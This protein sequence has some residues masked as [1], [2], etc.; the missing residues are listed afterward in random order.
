MAYKAFPVIDL[1][2]TGDNIRRLRLER[3]LT[4]KDLQGYFGFEEPRAIYKWQKG[5]TLPTVDNL[6]ALGV[7]FEVP[8]DRILVQVPSFT[9][10]T[11]NEQQAAARC[12]N[13][14]K[15]NF[16]AVPD[17]ASIRCN[18]YHFSAGCRGAAGRSPRRPRRAAR[19]IAWIFIVFFQWR[20]APRLFLWRREKGSLHERGCGVCGSDGIAPGEERISGR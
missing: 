9:H 15:R 3:G 20:G 19:K 4:V 2:A 7:L 1:I 8:M 13:I 11:K 18:V 12:S 5:E 16:P 17:T 14:F 6:F 10:N